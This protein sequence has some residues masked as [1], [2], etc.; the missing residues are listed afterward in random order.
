[1]ADTPATCI[2]CNASYDVGSSSTWED[3]ADIDSDEMGV[4]TS[5]DV[6][7]QRISDIVLLKELSENLK[8]VLDA[9]VN[10]SSTT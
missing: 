5:E 10:A 2:I 9:K 3:A 6:I 8:E 4:S 1:M 7:E